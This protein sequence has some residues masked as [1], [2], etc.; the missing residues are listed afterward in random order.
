MTNFLYQGNV[1]NYLMQSI[2][3]Q[4]IRT[5]GIDYLQAPI[6]TLTAILQTSFRYNL[7]YLD[8]QVPLIIHDTLIYLFKIEGENI[9][10]SSFLRLFGK[11]IPFCSMGP[12]VHYSIKAIL[13]F[14]HR[15]TVPEIIK[16]GLIALMNIFKEN[17]Y[18]IDVSIII[19][20]YI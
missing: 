4:R 16:E 18:I 8:P 10:T 6:Y 15:S 19:Y 9:I 1:L 7:H 12:S 5:L 2:S 11:L 14:T 13:E 17:S 20:N 3:E